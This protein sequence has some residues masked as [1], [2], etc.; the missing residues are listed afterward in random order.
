MG[1]TL[2]EV[3]IAITLLSVVLV[4]V[5]GAFR[6]GVRAWE[7]GERD[8]EQS[9]HLQIVPDLV[10]QQLASISRTGIFRKDEA[11]F[12]FYGDA[13]TM[14]FVSD[15]A[16]VPG[17]ELG[18]VL[19]MYRIVRDGKND[20]RSLMIYEQNIA[21]AEPDRLFDPPRD[22]DMVTLMGNIA[23]ITFEYLQSV[24]SDKLEWVNQWDPEQA[25]QIPQAVRIT[26]QT[27]AHSP[28]IRVVAPVRTQ[29]LAGG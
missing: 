6:I 11:P 18:R 16:L 19:V 21:F 14:S 4:I 9:Q 22:E 10:K 1:F 26:L 15:V 3:L 5:M 2:L 20:T 7:H 8:L 25:G 13:E 28:A 17:N 27:D 24:E 23:E 29:N 12:Y